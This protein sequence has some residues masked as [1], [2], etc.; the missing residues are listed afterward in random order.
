[1]RA[2]PALFTDHPQSVG[3]SYGEHMG[4]ALSFA[5][6]CALA[7][8]ACLLH[9]FLPFLFVKSGSRRIAALYERMVANRV[10]AQR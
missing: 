5:G 10:R 4:Q 6:G 3:E 1:M 7:A 9:A 2:L 8:F